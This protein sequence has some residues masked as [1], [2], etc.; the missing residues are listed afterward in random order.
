MNILLNGVGRVGK[1]IVRIAN[2]FENINI[3]AINELNSNIENIAYSINYDSTYG[4][5][6]DKYVVKNNFIEN[7]KN[8][9]EIL[10]F[11]SFT[12][13]DFTKYDI[14]IVVDAST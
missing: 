1:A 5:F 12:Q 6:E 11:K 13:I 8:R 2:T 3:V 10:N 14:D 4:R 7:S 9:I